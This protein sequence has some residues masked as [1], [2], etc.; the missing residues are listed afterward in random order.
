MAHLSP[1][2]GGHVTEVSRHPPHGVLV[3]APACLSCSSKGL[4]SLTADAGL[5][6]PVTGGELATVAVGVHGSATTRATGQKQATSS[7]GNGHTDVANPQD[8]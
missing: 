8:G 4:T 3:S 5:S 7:T 6:L 1:S 2:P